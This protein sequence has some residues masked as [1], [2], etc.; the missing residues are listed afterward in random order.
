VP[1]VAARPDRR[2]LLRLAG[3]GLL[4]I[5]VGVGA[6]LAAH[7]VGGGPGRPRRCSAWTCRRAPPPGEPGVLSRDGAPR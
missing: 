6:T 5:A 7:R 3:A 2:R 4:G 1:V